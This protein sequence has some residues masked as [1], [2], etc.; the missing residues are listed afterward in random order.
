MLH[1]NDRLH[2]F[3]SVP[4]G[5]M[6]VEPF[7]PFQRLIRNNLPT[8][9]NDLPLQESEVIDREGW[10]RFPRRPE[11]LLHAEMDTET[12]ILEPASAMP[13]QVF[14]LRNFGQTEQRAIEGPRFI[15]ATS[16]HRELNVMERQNG[17]H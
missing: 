2:Q 16:R 1:S 10:M 3:D 5:I 12:T 8:C 6:D 9:S 14:R 7:K 11:I 17:H 15:F 4:K 13:R